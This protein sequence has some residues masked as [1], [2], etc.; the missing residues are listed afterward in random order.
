MPP[1]GAQGLNSSL[2]DVAV[3]F[4]LA[5]AKP[6]TLGNADMLKLYHR[7]RF[8]DIRARAFGISALN[9]ASMVSAQPLCEA[10]AVVLHAL[11]GF[12]PLR[13]RVMQIGLGLPKS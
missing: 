2:K 5:K 9:R 13:K 4:Q 10:R 6:D 1:I 12:A 8:F 7:A 11:H 3:L